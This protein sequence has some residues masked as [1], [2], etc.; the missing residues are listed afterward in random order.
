MM[1]SD[2]FVPMQNRVFHSTQELNTEHHSMSK[3]SL[4]G[5]DSEPRVPPDSPGSSV[6]SR[7]QV[8]LLISFN[9]STF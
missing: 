4:S 1:S 2:G 7:L 9:A 8:E 3:S 6:S 5:G